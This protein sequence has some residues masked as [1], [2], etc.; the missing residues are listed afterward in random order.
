MIYTKIKSNDF[1]DAIHSSQNKYMSL[2]SGI[3]CTG[4]DPIKIKLL[5][6]K[7]VCAKMHH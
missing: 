2:N 5:L 3:L 7:C 6:S 4:I 1:S